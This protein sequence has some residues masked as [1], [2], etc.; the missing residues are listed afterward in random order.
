MNYPP[1]SFASH[2]ECTR[3][4]HWALLGDLTVLVF[5]RDRPKEV[6]RL[7]KSLSRFPCFVDV[8]DNGSEPLPQGLRAFFSK[9]SYTYRAG[10]WG[11]NLMTAASQLRTDFVCLVDDDGLLQPYGAA[12][13]LCRL[14]RDIELSAVEGHFA[15]F[16]VRGGRA[17]LLKGTELAPGAALEA[18]PIDR[19]RS[20]LQGFSETQY[21]SIYRSSLFALT[22]GFS[23][24]VELIATSR[25]VSPPL[26]VAMTAAHGPIGRS[27][28]LV[29]LREDSLPS[30]N[31]LAMDLWIGDWLADD[32]YK[33]EVVE[34]LSITRQSLT[35]LGMSVGDADRAISIF[36]ETQERRAHV[37][38]TIKTGPLAAIA[39]VT[40]PLRNRIREG[41]P[42]PSE[43]RDLQ[44]FREKQVITLAELNVLT[45]PT[46][47]DLGAI[48]WDSTD[49]QQTLLALEVD[50]GIAV[51]RPR[52][53]RSQAYFHSRQ[54]GVRSQS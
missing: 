54:T 49:A 4:E 18:D 38:P 12:S 47:L 2:C 37:Q 3:E 43:E 40:R 26:F 28:I 35:L 21:Y 45:S 6:E 52:D 5:T 42:S 17:V 53:L 39:R 30:H 1:V 19:W 51:D 34:V 24:N 41:R 14:H 32:Q 48:R 50:E 9:Q 46:I 11:H 7:L 29:T 33:S 23:A 44:D 31:K 36:L 22:F 8:Y 20:V 27:P 15:N 10:H 25:N 13:A 16:V